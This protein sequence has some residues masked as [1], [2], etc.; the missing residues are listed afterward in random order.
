MFFRHQH[1]Q[2][3]AKPDKPDQDSTSLTSINEKPYYF[4]VARL[5]QFCQFLIDR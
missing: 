4:I 5:L 1:L 2:Y 3:K